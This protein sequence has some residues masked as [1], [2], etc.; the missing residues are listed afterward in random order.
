MADDGRAMRCITSLSLLAAFA[1]AFAAPDFVE[2]GDFSTSASYG[3]NATGWDMYCDGV[4][5]GAMFL[6]AGP[7]VVYIEQPITG[8][9]VGQNYTLS[10][11]YSHSWFGDTQGLNDFAVLFQGGLWERDLPQDVVGFGP[12][13]Y[14]GF[15]ETFTAT[16]TSGVLRIEAQRFND[17]H[18]YVDNVSM[19]E[20]VPEPATLS[21]LGLGLL[22]AR[23]RRRAA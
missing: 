21:V 20:A 13:P 11:H 14:Y 23:R 22:S 15:S 12:G 10:L 18:S 2:N 9:T 4:S 8:L 7:G 19:V 3:D 17:N 6:N 5:D 16:A 1:S